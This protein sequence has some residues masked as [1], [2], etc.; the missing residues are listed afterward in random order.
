[1]RIHNEETETL[2]QRTQRRAKKDLIKNALLS[3]L[4]V[5]GALPIAIAAPKVFSLVAGKNMDLLPTNPK[6]RLRETVSRLKRK[7]LVEF[8]EEDGKRRMRLTPKGLTEARRLQS[9]PI[10]VPIPRRWDRRW[11]IVT[12]DIPERRRPLR[13]RVRLL[14]RRL[15]F[16][17]LQ[18]S[19]WI[20]PYDCEELI[21]LVKTD[22]RTGR[23]V[24]YIIADAVEYDKPLREHFKLPLHD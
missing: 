5:A 3:T 19:V 12:F 16:Y 6:Q 14:V 20:Y 10:P 7:G 8:R 1:M 17:R 24:L 21:T 9:V 2:E 4:I 13:D 18:D 23:D 15:G 11:R 22:L